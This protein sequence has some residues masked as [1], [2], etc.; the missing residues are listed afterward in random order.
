MPEPR[1]LSRA[2]AAA[3]L[4]VGETVFTA[5][6]RSGMWPAPLRRGARDGRLTW[7]RV[8]LDRAADRLA[9][10]AVDDTHD[11]S[12]AAAEQAA[13]EAASRVPTTHHR[14]PRR[15]EAA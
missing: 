15:H 8:L 9:G 11:S 7:D 13:I 5:E 2:E 4:G 12:L 6:V 1:F 14:R 3:Y 10:V